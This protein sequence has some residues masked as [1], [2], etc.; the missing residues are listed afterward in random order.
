MG[1]D[2][3]T[4]GASLPSSFH[5]N[6]SGLGAMFLLNAFIGGDERYINVVLNKTIHAWVPSDIVSSKREAEELVLNSYVQ[7]VRK[8]TGDEFDNIET[9]IKRYNDTTYISF[10]TNSDVYIDS[11]NIYAKQKS[12]GNN[13]P[14]RGGVSVDQ[15]KTWLTDDTP[16]PSK[17][18]YYH[19]VGRS[20]ML[21]LKRD[22]DINKTYFEIANHMPSWFYQ[23]LYVDKV[24][25]VLN[26]HKVNLFVIPTYSA[27]KA[28]P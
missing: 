8:V 15:S 3:L 2:I 1:A 19:I 4:N 10:Y 23:F 9:P 6:S 14:I 26:N 27:I 12:L 28:T 5:I 7:A 18:L 20:N 24:P 16:F 11:K 22:E 21:P 13:F 17:K 25:L